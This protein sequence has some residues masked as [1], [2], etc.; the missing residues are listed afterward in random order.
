[1]GDC[2]QKRDTLGEY[3][4]CVH[5]RNQE[6]QGKDHHGAEDVDQVVGTKEHHESLNKSLLKLNR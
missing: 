6:G 4:P 1:M 2:H 5:D 3:G